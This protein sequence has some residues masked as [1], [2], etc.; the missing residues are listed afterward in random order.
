MINKKSNIIIFIIIL[1][2]II[3]LLFKIKVEHFS[4][5]KKHPD[6]SYDCIYKNNCK[7]E[8]ALYWDNLKKQKYN[9]YIEPIKSS[10]SVKPK[11][12]KYIPYN[13]SIKL[14]KSSFLR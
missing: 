9:T 11:K 1:L 6:T 14:K 2:V 10:W 7:S 8:H 12:Y 5:T 4:I 3:Y 13:S